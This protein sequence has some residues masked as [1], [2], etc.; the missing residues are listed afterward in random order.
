MLVLAL[1]GIALA[2]SIVGVRRLTF[3]SD[4]LALLPQN[5]RVI[6]AFRDYLAR[7]GSLDQLYVVFTAPDDH[8]IGDYEDEIDAWI[9]ALRA[10][11]EIERAT[12]NGWPIGGSCCFAGRLWTTP[13]SACSR[14]EW[15]RLWPTAGSC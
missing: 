2:I 4:V 15:R 1:V 9:E 6:P 3:D 7:V 14:T 11:P 10:A 13:C 12:S 5:G 8:T